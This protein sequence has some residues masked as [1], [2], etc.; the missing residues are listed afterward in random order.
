MSFTSVKENS[1]VQAED[2]D[3][4]GG[5]YLKESDLY[6]VK[7]DMMYDVKA[8]SGAEAVA[9]VFKCDDDTEIK[10]TIYYTNKAGEHMYASKKPGG[11]KTP[12]MGFNLINSLFAVVLGPDT[13]IPTPQ[14]KEINIWNAEAK[15]ELPKSM[16]VYT[17]M[18]GKEVVLGLLKDRVNKNVKGD[19]GWVATNEDQEE[20]SINKFFSDKG[21][22][23]TEMKAKLEVP[24]FA[25]KWKAQWAGKVRDRFKPVAGLPMPASSS[26]AAAAEVTSVPL[27]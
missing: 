24:E 11:P 18:L 19:N 6:K 9:F 23:S 26:T 5:S 14:D 1:T 10:Q 12:S 22:T 13:A 8:A 16:P 15:A 25:A 27:W 2:N 4:L 7:I 3:Y 17:T 21:F 20:N